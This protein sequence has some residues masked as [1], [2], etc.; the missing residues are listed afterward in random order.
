M[1]GS[2]SSTMLGVLS[3]CLHGS[4]VVSMLA[5]L[6]MFVCLGQVC[7]NLLPLF[8]KLT[9][10]LSSAYLMDETNLL[11]PFGGKKITLAQNSLRN[12]VILE[13]YI[14]EVQKLTFLGITNLGRNVACEVHRLPSGSTS[15]WFTKYISWFWPDRRRRRLRASSAS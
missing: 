4:G 12:E 3:G 9:W 11:P 1:L 7:N 5:R 2:G 6:C 14:P 10:Q 13:P 8:R 15:V